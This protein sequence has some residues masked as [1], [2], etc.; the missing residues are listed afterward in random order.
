[1]DEY[2]LPNLK[3]P[4]RREVLAICG[5]GF[6]G[7]FAAEVLVRLEAEVGRPLHEVFDLIAGTSVGGLLALG[8]ADG[9]SAAELSDLLAGVGP[10][11]FGY[12]GLGVTKPKHDPQ[13]LVRALDDLFKARPLSSLKT[14]VLVP[15]IDM[16]Q[17]R[18]IMFRNAKGDPFRSLRIRD[19]ALATSAAPYFLPPHKV[20]NRLFADGGLAANA[21]E[22]VAASEAVHRLGWPEELV[23]VLVIGSTQAAARVAGYEIDL[24]WGAAQWFRDQNAL[25]LAMRAQM[26]LARDTAN[27][28]LGP[29]RL[30]VIDVVLSAKEA[31]AIGLDKATHDAAKSLRTLAENAFDEFVRDHALRLDRLKYSAPA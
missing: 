25:A 10:E 6:A 12:P 27:A 19:A 23:H 22:A 11:L 28:I 8:L 26:T 18:T 20:G 7:L 31:A 17:A 9:V 13:V 3:A 16:T 15:A 21:P 14:R 4:V 1:M 30:S 5:G 24:Q 2:E 29:D